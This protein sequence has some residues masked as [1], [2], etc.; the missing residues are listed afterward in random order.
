MDVQKR[1]RN[2]KA[3]FRMEQRGSFLPEK[4]RMSRSEV[5]AKII[6]TFESN[7]NVHKEFVSPGQIETATLYRRGGDYQGDRDSLSNRQ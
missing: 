3:K 5:K 1:F 6:A 4:V 2:Q 7:D